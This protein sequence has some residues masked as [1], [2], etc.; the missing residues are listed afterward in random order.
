MYH[1][2]KSWNELD[3][4]RSFIACIADLYVNFIKDQHIPTMNLMLKKF[5][6]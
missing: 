5:T 3:K 1:V 6:Q 4:R 2:Y